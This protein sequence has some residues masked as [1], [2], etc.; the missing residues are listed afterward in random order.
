MDVTDVMHAV[1]A[2]EHQVFGID[3]S[4]ET[5]LRYIDEVGIDAAEGN[6]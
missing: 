1:R 3:P 4:D 5:T 2:L 6:A